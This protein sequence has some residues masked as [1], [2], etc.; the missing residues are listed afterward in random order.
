MSYVLSHFPNNLREINTKLY[1]NTQLVYHCS[2]DK[3]P[4]TVPATVLFQHVTSG[5]YHQ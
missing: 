5:L 1:C 3:K 2:S 4:R